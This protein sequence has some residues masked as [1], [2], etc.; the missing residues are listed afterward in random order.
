MVNQRV[1]HLCA[2]RSFSL[3]ASMQKYFV[4]V[5]AKPDLVLT[6]GRGSRLFDDV[7]KREYIDFVAGIAVTSLGHSDPAIAEVIAAQSA[8]LV[9]TSNLFH[10]SEALK[11]AEKL[12][13]STKRFGGQQDAEKVYFCNS[14]T[15]ANE[16]ALK[17]SR[18]RA[19]RTDPQKQGFI[20]FE[21]SF[22]GRTMGSLSVTSKAKYRLPFGDMV[23]HVTFLNIHDP[24]EKLV[25]FIVENAPKTAAMILE[26]IQGEGGVHRV[27][28][29]KLVALGRLCKKH[30]IVLIYD[31][32]Q[33]GLGRTG[34]LWA[35]SNLP[36][37]A[38]PDIFTTAKA[39]GN[40]FPMGATV[41]NSKVNE[42]LSVGD[43]GTT[44]GGN[45]LACAVGNHVLDRIAQQPFLD[46]VKAKANV[47]TAGLLA[48]QKKY[49]FI[50]EIRGD[51]LLIGVEFTVDVSDIISKSRERGLLITA[52]GPNTLR[53]IPA[54]TI[55]EDTI[56]QGL[57]ILESVV[58]EISSS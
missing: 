48:L 34:K 53:I 15:E 30:D 35:H 14:G 18:R 19:L 32:I 43:H 10:N 26:P 21:N 5:Y 54:L 40:G 39:L 1:V 37:D 50:R 9:H 7:N 17:F 52:A 28:E 4:D 44:Y 23:P 36:A 27:P 49:P 29:D 20:A 56:R 3:T 24:V 51:G 47:F 22:H 46:D 55:E 41:V 13:E 42:V 2:K 6:R 12:V 25:S 58:G 33:C 45:P 31:E 8:T 11:F 57:E 38:H 16:A